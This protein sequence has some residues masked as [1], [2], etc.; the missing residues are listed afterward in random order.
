MMW[1]IDAEIWQNVKKGKFAPTKNL[2]FSLALTLQFSMEDV[3][4]LFLFAEYEWDYTYVKDVVISYLLINKV[5]N[6]EM[7]SAALAEYKVENLFIK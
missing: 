1:N 6:R 5:Y 2:I 3:N 7:I 4:A